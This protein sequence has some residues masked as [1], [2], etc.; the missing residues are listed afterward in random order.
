VH[1]AALTRATL[2]TLA[3]V[4]VASPAGT[5]PKTRLNTGLALTPFWSGT[6]VTVSGRKWREGESHDV[7]VELGASRSVFSRYFAVRGTARLGG[8]GSAWSDN[9]GEK[10]GHFDLDIGPELHIPLP[11]SAFRVSLPFGYSKAWVHPRTGRAVRD[12]YVGGHG[13]TFGLVAAMEI[14]GDHHGGYFGMS[15]LG[16]THWF[17]HETALVADPAVRATEQYRINVHSA[18]FQ[19]GYGLRF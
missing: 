1:R 12:D 13:V 10:R 3:A 11:A 19:L 16:R 7:G 2:V 4:L 14:W 15:Y 9:R 6:T 18:V 17:D 5:E 8:W